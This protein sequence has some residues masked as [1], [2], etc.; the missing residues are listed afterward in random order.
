MET[1]GVKV[2]TETRQGLQG[3]YDVQV[4]LPVDTAK[5][6]ANGADDKKP[7]P[8]A[9]DE[10][11][12]AAAKEGETEVAKAEGEQQTP[13]QL[14]AKKQ[15]KFQRRLDRQKEARV[16]AETEA[17]LLRERLA[18]FEGT[19]K[20][21]DAASD[22]NEPQRDQFEDY[23][24]YLRALAR[25]DAKQTAGDTLKVDREAR[26]KDE[27]GKLAT[28]QERTLAKNWSER[29]QVF[30]KEQK[31]YLDVVA[32]FIEDGLDS[33]SEVARRA[34]AESELGPQLLHHLAQHDEV[35]ESIA[36]L[37]PLQQVKELGKLEAKVAKPQV[38]AGK[39][40]SEAPD[41]VSQTKVGANAV[42]GYREG[43]S[44]S[45]YREWRKS[46]GARWAR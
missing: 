35:A 12:K 18:T 2:A 41:P 5:P 33:L 36:G 16:A 9:A 6:P 20:P 31:D 39:I 15:S 30:Q 3:E 22:P 44:D 25:Y 26:E 24:T 42:T 28:A 29:E 40:A 17:R 13:E 34:I 45:E 21:A 14:E 32:P 1:E 38:K 4:A 37:S 46:N 23:E 10:A 8:G 43:M 7:L 19:K 11:T 27:S